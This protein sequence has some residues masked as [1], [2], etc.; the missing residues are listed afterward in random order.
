VKTWLNN[1]IFRARRPQDNDN[2]K[3]SIA[4]GTT[5]Y[6][7]STGS[8]GYGAMFIM[9]TNV[10]ANGAVNF[11][12]KGTF[13]KRLYTEGNKPFNPTFGTGG[14]TESSNHFVEGPLT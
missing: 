9:P 11:D 4:S 13:V 6:K 3:T 8:D 2:I 12:S 14:D 1:F 7:L 5:N 10:F